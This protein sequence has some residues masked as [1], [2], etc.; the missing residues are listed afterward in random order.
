MKKDLNLKRRGAPGSGCQASSVSPNSVNA[1][2][3]ILASVP[4][5][6]L[7]FAD[8]ESGQRWDAGWYRRV[9]DL[10]Q[11][12]ADAPT[13]LE[14]ER[15]LDMLLWCIVDSGPV[16]VG[17]APSID[18]AADAMQRLRKRAFI[19]RKTGRRDA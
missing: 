9:L 1:Y 18:S 7:A 5:E 10:S 17:F 11:K 13:E 8:T 12:A 3:N 6:V 2:T 4:R 19:D 15:Y 14:A 16:G